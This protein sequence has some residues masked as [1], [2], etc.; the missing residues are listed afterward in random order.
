MSFADVVKGSGQPSVEVVINAP[1]ATSE[2]QGKQE[3]N[4]SKPD[5]RQTD[6]HAAKPDNKDSQSSQHNQNSRN[7]Q[8]S[9]QTAGSGS[10]SGNS[11][12]ISQPKIPTG[13]DMPDALTISADPDANANMIKYAFH[14]FGA[15]FVEVHINPKSGEIRIARVVN[16]FDVGKI[17]NPKTANSQI[18]GG[19]I[20]GIGMALLEETV[21][22]TRTGR[23]LN[24]DLAEYH[25]P[26][27]AD[28]P[29][30][31]TYFLDIPDP[32]IGGPGAR[33]VGEIGIT[34][35]AA[36][37]A[38]AVYHATGKRVRDLPITLDKIV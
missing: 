22:D 21:T 23:I 19:T 1:T 5:A 10:G 15:Q 28:I 14:S 38:N 6:K 36:A 33:G 24:R 26:V 7:S 13:G 16:V 11:D 29:P 35:V 34:G 18:V 17:L 12:T 9:G 32:H 4:K 25:V 27:N 31:E 3:E 30:I 37:V 20:M 2:M 8:K